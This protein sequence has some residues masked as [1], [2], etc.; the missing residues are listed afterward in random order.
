MT[1]TVCIFPEKEVNKILFFIIN[2]DHEEVKIFKGHTLAYLTPAQY[3]TLSETR[4][5]NQESEVVHISAVA[6]D[7]NVKYYQLFQQVAK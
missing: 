1:L 4:E 6:S 3:D 2:M 5:N 7:P